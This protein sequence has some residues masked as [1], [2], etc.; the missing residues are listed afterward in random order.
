MSY[1]YI[2]IYIY[3]YVND[4]SSLRVNKKQE[5]TLEFQEEMEDQQY[6][7]QT[8]KTVNLYKQKQK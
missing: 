7:K 1:V 6:A 3:I 5:E 2:Y 4:I 8:G